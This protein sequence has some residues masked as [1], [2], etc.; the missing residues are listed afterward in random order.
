MHRR[1]D[2][3]EYGGFMGLNEESVIIKNNLS[4]GFKPLYSK[5]Y[6]NMKKMVKTDF[7]KVEIV[8]KII[9]RILRQ[10]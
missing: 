1:I 2:D 3:P 7:D 8:P 4:E 5:I 9:N 10:I 6:S